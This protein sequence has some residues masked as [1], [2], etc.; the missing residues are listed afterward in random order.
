M[1]LLVFFGIVVIV[2]AILFP[3]VCRS[4]L[5][6]GVFYTCAFCVVAL[7]GVYWFDPL[8]TFLNDLFGY[9]R[10]LQI[11]FTGCLLFLLFFIILLMRSAFNQTQEPQT[12]DDKDA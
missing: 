11:K 7:I 9:R 12:P 10:M 8:N 4:L 2:A 1:G 5:R 6:E 3:N